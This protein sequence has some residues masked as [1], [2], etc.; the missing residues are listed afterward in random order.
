[1]SPQLFMRRAFT[2]EAMRFAGPDGSTSATSGNG[3]E[4]AA[5]V[6]GRHFPGGDHYAECVE[7]DDGVVFTGE[8]VVRGIHGAFYVV[9]PLHFEAGYEP[10]NKDHR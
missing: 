1:M 4:V 10:V 6:G 8:Y 3:E 7:W 5:W 2:V 9:D